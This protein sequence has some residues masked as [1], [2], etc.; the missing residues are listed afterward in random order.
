[1]TPRRVCNG[2]SKVHRD[3]LAL[4]ELM[5]KEGGHVPLVN[6]D[7]AFALGFTIRRG[8][9]VE[10]DMARFHRAR[11]HTQDGI[12]K[13]GKPCCG[14]RLHYREIRGSTSF[15]LID[16]SAGAGE[17]ALAYIAQLLGWLTR[18]RQRQTED[19]RQ[20]V[21]LEALAGLARQL[22]D[23]VGSQICQ[24][25]MIEL[26]EFATIKPRTIGEMTSWAQGL[27]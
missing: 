20:I 8:S 12:W 2:K 13:N 24:R 1:M 3:A 10:I 9:V 21:T 26:D 4:V 7:L 15:V 6:K 14:Y 22:N 17:Y 19:R 18:L 16:E 5:F 23:D 11:N 25:A 27:Q